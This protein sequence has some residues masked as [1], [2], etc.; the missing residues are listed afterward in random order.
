LFVHDGPVELA[1]SVDVVTGAIVVVGMT[2]MIK[3]QMS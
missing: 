3:Q 2:M 1:T